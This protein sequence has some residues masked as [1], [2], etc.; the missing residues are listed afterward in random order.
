MSSPREKP[1]ELGW[2]EVGE[3]V[4]EFCGHLAVQAAGTVPHRVAADAQAF[5][6]LLG[7]YAKSD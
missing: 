3:L 5:G 7:G 4:D 6:E 1:V 2:S